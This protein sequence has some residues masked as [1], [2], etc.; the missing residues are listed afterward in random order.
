MSVKLID[1]AWDTP[2]K[3]NDLLVLIALCDWANDDGECFPKQET[4]IKRAKIS[5]STLNMI[6]DD[7]EEIGLITRELRT[8]KNGNFSSTIYKLDLSISFE[9]HIEIKKKRRTRNSK[10]IECG[11]G[12]TQ[13][14]DT[15]QIA[16]E[17]IEKNV[18]TVKNEKCGHG[19]VKN[20]DMPYYIYNRQ[21][22]FNRQIVGVIPIS[23]DTLIDF[24]KNRIKMKK[25]MSDEALKRFGNQLRKYDS[26]NYDVEAMVDEAIINNW[27]GLV[28]KPKHKKT[29]SMGFSPKVEAGM[30][31]VMDFMKE[32]A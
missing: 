11:Q 16:T 31:A 22:S 27:Q 17:P 8:K 12:E 14:V 6:L 3:S 20:V 9:N 29:S 25:P 28:E 7:F 4:I 2:L 18:D 23:E 5:R 13:N 26:Q 15:P 19:E 30:S 24:V 1:K 21:Y 10:K 32:E